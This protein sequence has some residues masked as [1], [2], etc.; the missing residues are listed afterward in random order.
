VTKHVTSHTK[1]YKINI[2]ES[3]ALIMAL[4]NLSFLMGCI[5]FL[6][7]NGFK[8]GGYLPKILLIAFILWLAN[9]AFSIM[10]SPIVLRYQVFPMIISAA[11]SLIIIEYIIDLAN[12]GEPETTAE[13]NPSTDASPM[14][15]SEPLH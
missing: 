13:I 15:V 5:S 3:Y 4:V 12:A 1:F 9:S 7:L 2:T 14:P 6:I 10:A 8:N 11:F